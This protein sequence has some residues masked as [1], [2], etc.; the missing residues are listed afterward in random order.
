MLGSWKVTTAPAVEPVT[1]TEA[2]SHLRVGAPPGTAAAITKAN[3]GVATK[4]SHGLATGDVVVWTAASGMV[5]LD[6]VTTT[7]TYVDGDSYS[8][9]VN[10]T[11]YTTSDGTEAY[12]PTHDDDSYISDL[13]TTARERVELDEERK[14][15]TQTIT[16]KLDAFP[17]ENEIG[18]P[19]PIQSV[20]SIKYQDT[21]DAQQTFDAASYL[22]DAYSEPGRIALASSQSWPSTYG[23]VG[24]VEIIFIAGYGDT[25]AD[26]PLTSRQAM[27][28][29]VGDLYEHREYQVDRITLIEN[30]A[31]RALIGRRKV[32]QYI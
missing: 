23:E 28:L 13:I 7:V 27:L 4:H 32:E 31:Y 10:T 29:L 17:S 14:L 2:K 25:A 1:L 5:E 12:A 21:A 30:C 20:T 18:L 9:G 11:A 16:L 6:G 19:L 22:V 24:D 15:V 26:V 8:I 3:P